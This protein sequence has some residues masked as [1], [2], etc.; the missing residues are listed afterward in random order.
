MK[1]T[2]LT[3]LILSLFGLGAASQ[4][5]ESFKLSTDKPETGKRIHFVYTGIFSKKLDPRI[6]LYYSQAKRSTWMTLN[7]KYTGS[8]TEGWFV[9]PDSVLA[10]CIKPRNHRDS[11]E[12]FVFQVYKDGKALKGSYASAA[13]FYGNIPG[14]ELTEVPQA[15]ALYRYE[16]G[17]HP[18]IR[19]DYLLS[20]FFSAAVS[21]DAQAIEDLSRTWKDSLQHGKSEQFL[22][23]L[24]PTAMRYKNLDIRGQLKAN[25]LAKYPN[26]RFAFQEATGNINNK[27]EQEDFAALLNKL[28][29]DYPMSLKSGEFDRIYQRYGNH[30]IRKGLFAAYDSCVN[31]IVDQAT[32]K[33]LYASGASTLLKTGKDLEKAEIYLQKALSLLDFGLANRPPYVFGKSDWHKAIQAERGNYLDILAQIQCGLGKTDEAIN[34]LKEALKI[35]D[36]NYEIRI[37]YVKY[38]LDTEQY[39]S[40]LKAASGFVKSALET[41]EMKQ[42]LM[43]SYSKKNDSA[44]GAEA[45]YLALVNARDNA[46]K[47][48]KYS[49][50]NIKS[51]DIK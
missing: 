28:E 50:L 18:D 27:I 51:I 46:Y 38:L 31:K 11:S 49:R 5:N 40:A 36:Y 30:L 1:Y 19:A 13:T 7:A 37:H 17:L 3:L 26:G 25:L 15:L 32:K 23:L 24:Y 4:Q 14:A 34:H 6:T 2:L 33:A 16:F 45:Y 44:D 47:V 20:Y 9:L 39:K 41:E 21:P 43:E 10:F 22:T 42:L 29:N 12:L 48:P 8:Q 35:N